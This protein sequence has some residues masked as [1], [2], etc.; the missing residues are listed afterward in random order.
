MSES[1]DDTPCAR[2]FSS[3]CQDGCD[4]LGHLGY[5]FWWAENRLEGVFD[6]LLHLDID[7]LLCPSHASV[8][9]AVHVN[10]SSVFAAGTRHD[11]IGGSVYLSIH[12]LGYRF[13][14]RFIFEASRKGQHGVMYMYSILYS[15]SAPST[16][17]RT[18]QEE[19]ISVIWLIQKKEA[20][21]RNHRASGFH[22]IH[23]RCSTTAP[24]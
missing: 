7:A 17:A 12:V 10:L 24:L 14:T 16:K 1:P 13:V 21:F 23:G 20:T 9:S 15:T 11:H 22:K 4:S 8:H 19:Q 6:C 5:G 18:L 3:R 2:V